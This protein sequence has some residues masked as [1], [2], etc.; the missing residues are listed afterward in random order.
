MGCDMFY[1]YEWFIIETGEIFY[2][3]KG[4]N[5]RYK[6]RKHNKMFNEFVKRFHS[7]SRIIAEFSTE[8]EAFEYEYKRIEELREQGQCVCNIKNGGF[9]GLAASL[10]TVGITSFADLWPQFW[11][12]SLIFSSEKGLLYAC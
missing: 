11:S 4:T 6:V 1:V 2:V 12:H 9:G 5:R 3:G 7:N 8:Q 10:E